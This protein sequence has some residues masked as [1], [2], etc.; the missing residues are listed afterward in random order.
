[1]NIDPPQQGLSAGQKTGFIFLLVFGF[2]AVGLGFVQMRNNIFGPF[3][4]SPGSQAIDQ[5][6]VAFDQTVRLQSI[7]TDQDGI[8]DFEELTFYHTSPFLP[9]TD[10]D[11]LSDQEEID[12]GTDPL[13]PEGRDCSTAEFVPNTETE[14][15]DVSLTPVGGDAVGSIGEGFNPGL[16]MQQLLGDPTQLRA[17]L[18]STGQFTEAQLDAIDDEALSQ[19]AANVIQKGAPSNINLGTGSEAGSTVSTDLTELLDDPDK[20]RQALIDTGNISTADLEKIDDDMLA[21]IAKEVLLGN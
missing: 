2:L 19:M 12:A 16:Q 14:V 10:S 18:L 15:E 9:D 21:E 11:G 3:F 8:K 6:Q 4:V 13:C 1:M 5:A 17:M 7:D 20:L